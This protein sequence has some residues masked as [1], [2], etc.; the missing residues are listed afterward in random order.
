ML[1]SLKSAKAQCL[2]SFVAAFAVAL[3]IV[4]T[5][6]AHDNGYKYYSSS[7]TF[8]PNSTN[9]KSQIQSAASDYDST[10]LTVTYSTNSGS[11]YGNINYYQSNYGATG[12]IARAQG[13]NYYNEKC[14]LDDGSGLTGKCNR[15]EMRRKAHYGAVYLDLADQ[16]FIDAHPNFVIRHEAGHILGMAHGPCDEDT[17]MVPNCGTLRATLSTHDRTNM[18]NNY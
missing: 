17:V 2:F 15:T 16:S 12:W 10:D 18:N 5:M 7:V 3:S 1:T 4:P 14:A 8:R 9:W 11:G 13:W 6:Y